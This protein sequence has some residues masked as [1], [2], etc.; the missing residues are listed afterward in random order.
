MEQTILTKEQQKVLKTVAAEPGMEPYYLSGGTALAAY[1]LKHRFS[2]D[3]DFF[4]GEQSD[5]LFLH[6]FA[7]KIKEMLSASEMRFEKLHDRNQFFLQL[8]DHELKIEFTLYPFSHLAEPEKHDGVAVDS[9]HDIAAGKLMAFTDRFDP[10]DFVD[11]YFLL[12]KFSFAEL[13][14]DVKQKFSTTLDDVFLGGLCARVR[15]IEALPR[16]LLPLSLDELKSFFTERA[17]ELTPNIFE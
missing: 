2:D 13:R 9:L 16:L 17:K 6:G 15:R 4:T 7:E 3:L 5:S 14:A 12:Q 1:Y 8:G 11:L 10:K